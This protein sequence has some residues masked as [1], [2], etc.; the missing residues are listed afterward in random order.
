MGLDW[1]ETPLAMPNLVAWF[2]RQIL[3]G[4]LSMP[5]LARLAADAVRQGKPAIVGVLPSV[6]P[7]IAVPMEKDGRIIGAL[8]VARAAGVSFLDATA[9]HV[10]EVLAAHTGTAVAN[11]RAYEETRRQSVTDPHTGA[12]NLRQLTVT[13]KREVER[14]TRFSRPLTVLVLDL[15]HFKQVNDVHGHAVGSEVLKAFAIRVLAC[16][17]EVDVFARYGGDEFVA[18]LPETDLNSGMV[19]ANR[20]LEAVCGL[21][22]DSSRGGL[23]LGA[24]IGLAVLPAHGTSAQQLFNAADHAMYLAKKRGGSQCATPSDSMNQ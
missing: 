1:R 16:L 18:V 5:Q 24:S 15:D 12:G 11:V 7:A 20:I 2:A 6:G 21:S 3:G 17:R 13:L 10:V 19:V 4:N 23:R 8:S 22:F 9:V 14:A